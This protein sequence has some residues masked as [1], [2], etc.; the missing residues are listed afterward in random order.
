M[1]AVTSF[2]EYVPSRALSHRTLLF[3]AG[4]FHSI[5]PLSASVDLSPSDAGGKSISFDPF[6][7]TV[8]SRSLVA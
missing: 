1:T 7:E 5:P 6:H 3:V 4:R 2:V 8:F